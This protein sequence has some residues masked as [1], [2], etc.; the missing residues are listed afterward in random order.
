MLKIKIIHN[1]KQLKKY[2]INVSKNINLNK[3]F[4][5]FNDRSNN[6]SMWKTTIYGEKT[7]FRR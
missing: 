2:F 6:K 3:N 1:M 4:F 5:I 7:V